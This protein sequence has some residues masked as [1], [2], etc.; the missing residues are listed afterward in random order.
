M[1]VPVRPGMVIYDGNP[2]V[3]LERT[4][5]I[6][7]GASVRAKVS[8]SEWTIGGDVTASKPVRCFDAVQ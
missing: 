8:Q 4:Q 1:S 5:S 7:A 3:E 6:D 2:G